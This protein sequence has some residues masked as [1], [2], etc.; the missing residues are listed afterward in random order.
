MT[1][2]WTHKKQRAMEYRADILRADLRAA[3]S[4]SLLSSFSYIL[5]P[6]SAHTGL[7][8]PGEGNEHSETDNSADG[9]NA[10]MDYPYVSSCSESIKR[11]E[12]H[13]I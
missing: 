9:S 5:T 2:V 10:M 8:P 7:C 6:K 3:A 4:N 11:R 13:S 1:G 12:L